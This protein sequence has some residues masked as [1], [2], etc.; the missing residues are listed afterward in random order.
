MRNVTGFVMVVVLLALMAA[1]AMAATTASHTVTVQV[2]SINELALTG[3]NIT[4]TISAAVAGS[5]PTAATSTTCQLNWT[6]NV[7]TKKV[8]VY[9]SIVAQKFSLTVQA[10]SITNGTSAGV[11]SLIGQG[12]GSASDFVTGI[13]ADT[14][15]CTLS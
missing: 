8:T 15:T 2:D 9:E 3:G 10:T 11:V 12:V 1:S 14:G 13:A 4:L 5:E 6:T 7:G